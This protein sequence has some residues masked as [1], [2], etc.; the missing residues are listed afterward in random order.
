[1]GY[2]YV[3]SSKSKFLKNSTRIYRP[4]F[5]ENKPKTLVFNDWKRA[6]S[7]CFLKTGSINSGTDFRFDAYNPVFVKKDMG[8]YMMYLWREI[9]VNRFGKLDFTVHGKME[10]LLEFALC[11]RAIAELSLYL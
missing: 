3:R 11:N 7:A 1:M 4:S 6:F 9:Y 8:V 5:R 10:S 2:C